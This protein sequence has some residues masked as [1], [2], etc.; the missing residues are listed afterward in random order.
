MGEDLI[1]EAPRVSE[2]DVTNAGDEDIDE[3]DFDEDIDEVEETCYEYK[4]RRYEERL[5][6][7]KE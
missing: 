5:A 1:S 6:K 2:E 7:K 4:Q 3:D